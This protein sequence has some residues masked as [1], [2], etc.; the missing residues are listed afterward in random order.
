MEEEKNLKENKKKGNSLLIVII[1]LLII[2][3]LDLAFY[4]CYDKGIIFTKQEETSTEEKDKDK[5][6]EEENVTFSDNEL[7]EYIDYIRP[8]SIGPSPLLYNTSYVNS[9]DLSA[10]EKIQYLGSY[11]YEKTTT[12][13]DFAYN[14][15]SESDVEKA[16]SK[17][18]GPNTYEKTKFNLG[19][20][21]YILNETDHNYYSKNGC[22]GASSMF[23]GSSIIGYKATKSKL[24][25][26]TAYVVYIGEKETIYKDYDGTISLETLRYDSTNDI[27]EYL[28]EYAKNNQDKLYHI[29]Y[30]FESNNGRNYYFK[31]LKNDKV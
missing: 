14:I 2:I 5:E 3:I 25:I 10:A 18:Y 19:C 4:I 22:G 6:D 11:I 31:E 13:Q 27:R 17:V 24:E 8:I 29:V 1:I 15:I 26:T 21:D 28:N 30:T 12:S 20:G 16:V 9:S 23:V 7:E